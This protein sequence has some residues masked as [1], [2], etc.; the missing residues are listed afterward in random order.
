MNKNVLAHN[1]GGWEVQYQD[2]N[3]CQGAFMLRQPMV[4][5]TMWQKGKERERGAKSFLIHDTDPFMRTEP[6]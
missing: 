5:G 2:T 1:S 6:L 4:E 3:I